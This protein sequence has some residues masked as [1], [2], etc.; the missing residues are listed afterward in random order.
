ML[1]PQT[2]YVDLSFCYKV[3]KL[4]YSFAVVSQRH[5]IIKSFVVKDFEPWGKPSVK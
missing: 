2:I 5:T 4:F 1:K 3:S